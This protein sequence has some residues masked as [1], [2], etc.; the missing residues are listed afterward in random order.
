MSSESGE[1][2]P[3][4][5]GLS[6]AEAMVIA[7]FFAVSIW[8]CVQ[9]FV[10]IF[11][12]FKIYSGLYFWSMTISNTA[13]VF[14]Q[15]FALVRFFGL[16]PTL[17]VTPLVSV[18]FWVM[19]TGQSV[20]LYSRLC[21]V[22]GEPIKLRWVLGLITFTFL[23]VEVPVS[24]LLIASNVPG[25]EHLVRAFNVFENCQTGLISAQ[26]A[27]ISWLYVRE[28]KRA[29]KPIQVI[30][31]QRVKKTMKGLVWLFVL[32]ALLDLS[33]MGLA[34]S[35][36]QFAIM[37]SYK[38]VVYSIKLQVEGI[39]LNSLT[40]LMRRRSCTCG[41]TAAENYT[42]SPITVMG[43]GVGDQFTTPCHSPINKNIGEGK[44]SGEDLGTATSENVERHSAELRRI[45]GTEQYP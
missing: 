29:F 1:T 5:N 42:S 33:L 41:S 10:F 11:V 14:R 37:T 40:K 22:V 16:A 27:L 24:S 18:G 45:F 6:L 7:G 8:N 9:T 32:T 39:V 19:V 2:G 26:E 21:L 35:G 3:I 31:G 12:T 17:A 20:V 36:Q 44:S 30:K 23:F 15:T 4:E 38:G 34:Y 28:A 25:Q 13:I 43:V